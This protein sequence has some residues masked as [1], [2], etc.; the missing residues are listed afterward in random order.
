MQVIFTESPF[1]LAEGNY[2]SINQSGGENEK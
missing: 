1:F 2:T